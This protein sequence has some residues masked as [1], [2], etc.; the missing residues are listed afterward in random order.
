MHVDPNPTLPAALKQ[1]WCH[2][3]R[4]D[5]Y[6]SSEKEH[7]TYQLTVALPRGESPVLFGPLEVHVP[8]T[9]MTRFT[10]AAPDTDDYRDAGMV[11]AASFACLSVATFM[12]LHSLIDP[13]TAEPVNMQ[14][15]SVTER[16]QV[17]MGIAACLR[18]KGYCH[19]EGGQAQWFDPIDGLTVDMAY[20]VI[21]E[22]GGQQLDDLGASVGCYQQSRGIR[23]QIA[24]SKKGRFTP[25]MAST[26]LEK[27]TK[28]LGPAMEVSVFENNSGTVLRSSPGFT[29]EDVEALPTSP[30]G[31][32]PFLVPGP[33]ER[34]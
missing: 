29:R 27:I 24:A 20:L 4:P 13:Q 14:A 31:V 17:A 22:I 18:V 19:S 23:V 26:L 1:C 5:K 25:E 33:T 11:A 28:K 34:S 30:S 32:P 3:N 16:V 7:L 15:A 10:N 21:R 9:A 12:T 2:R 8:L 6:F